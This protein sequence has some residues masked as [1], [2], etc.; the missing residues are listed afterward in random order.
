MSSCY[1][2]C[3]LHFYKHLDAF[4]LCIIH[5]C[6]H[7][8]NIPAADIIRLFCLALTETETHLWS[9]PPHLCSSSICDELSV[10]F[11]ADLR[12][13]RIAVA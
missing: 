11:H 9:I 3:C 6:V 1:T 2:S 5:K 10:T 12:S 4:G 13:V 8:A 7:A